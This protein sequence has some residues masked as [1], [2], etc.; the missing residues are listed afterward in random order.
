MLKKI[1]TYIK[2]G[3]VFY[4]IEICDTSSDKQYH[5]IEVIKK[6]G[7]LIISKEKTITKVED[8]PSFIDKKDSPLFLCMNTKNVVT[9][10]TP[11]NSNKNPEAIVHS[12]FPNLSFDNFYYQISQTK[13]NTIISIVKKGEINA[14]LEKLK[15]LKLLVTNFS[16][17]I[18]NLTAITSYTQE[19]QIYTS[20]SKIHLENNSIVS[21]SDLT[22]KNNFNIISDLKVANNSILG[23]SSVINYI[24]KGTQN[25]TNF[26]AISE[27]LEN[28]F[29]NK[30]FF[31]LLLKSFLIL[32]LSILVI[33]FLIFSHYFS[34]VEVLETTLS[35]NT[36][37][38]EH[39]QKLKTKVEKK[40]EFV[41]TL[42]S[43][44]NS[45]SSYY[46]DQ[47]AQSIPNTIL[48]D[49]IRYQPFV[50]PVRESKPIEVKSNII[51][52][53]GK[54]ISGHDFSLWIETV[55]KLD[56]VISVKTYDYDYNSKN[57]SNF[58]IKIN[59]YEDEE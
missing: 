48:L 39:L 37:N 26:S 24:S 54:T 32:V 25:L 10:L 30:R 1:T 22:D 41:N 8:I 57:T 21:I 11:L 9:K 4:A 12:I 15:T 5:I 14:L 51:T 18:S 38:K 52:V 46:T 58:S 59:M 50:K 47:I 31:N 36:I 55:E 20:N 33:N 44:A 29:K 19:N 40:E 49:E 7:E 3:L 28:E 13:I 53:S 23:F 6:K 42:L 34:K 43:A 35:A 17:G 2:E 27:D 56:W 16:L 45:K